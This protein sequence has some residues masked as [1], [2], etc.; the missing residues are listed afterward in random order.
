LRREPIF[1]EAHRDRDV[2]LQFDFVSPVVARFSGDSGSGEPNQVLK[3]IGNGFVAGAR[4]EGG[5][6][7]S[8]PLVK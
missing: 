6:V 5:L 7:V 3:L 8:I 4:K 2:A 1:F